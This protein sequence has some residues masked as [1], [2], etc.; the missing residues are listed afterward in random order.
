[1]NFRINGEFNQIKEM[2]EG[3]LDKEKLANKG[4]G[5]EK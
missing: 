1:M 2:I 5:K 4:S 3:Y